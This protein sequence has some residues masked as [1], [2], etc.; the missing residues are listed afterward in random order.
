MVRAN[1]RKKLPQRGAKT[2]FSPFGGLSARELKTDFGDAKS[3]KVEKWH[4]GPLASP[5]PR[6]HA[7]PLRSNLPSNISSPSKC[8]LGD[9]SSRGLLG[10]E[11]EPRLKG[12]FRDRR[13]LP[14]KIPKSQLAA[15][16]DFGHA[17]WANFRKKLPKG[18]ENQIGG[19]A[20][21]ELENIF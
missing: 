8:Y 19:F 16:I 17:F 5:P 13:V 11:E 7:V 6:R 9:F 21:R 4:F 12:H 1:L 3:P 10:A 2:S 15:K 14:V 20:A 18:R